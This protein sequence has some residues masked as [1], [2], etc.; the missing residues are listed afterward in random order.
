M[1]M[2]MPNDVTQEDLV[3]SI[4]RLL[5]TSSK[6]YM[7]L[8]R[9][10][11][12]RFGR[13][14]ERSVRYGLR[15]YGLWRGME[16]RQAHHALGLEINMKNLIGC[17][18]SAST[19][20]IKDDLAETG[21]TFKPYDARHDVH[22]CPAAEV[23]T[24]AEFFQWG[25]AYC[26]EFHQACASAY[27]PDG[28]VVIPIN[29]MKGDDHCH[30]QWIMPP[31]SETLDLGE[32]SPLGRRLALDYQDSSEL[33]GAWHAL[34]R[35]NRLVGGRFYTAA[36]VLMEQ[37]GE[38]GIEVI[39]DGLTRWGN[40]R[41]RTLRQEHEAGGIPLN[42]VSFIQ[43]HD[44]PYRQVWQTREIVMEPNH[45]VLEIADSP[46]DEAWDDLKG[47]DLGA[48]WYE[49][50]YAAMAATYL[51]GSSARW[52]KLKSRQDAVNQLEISVG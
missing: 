50:S 45:V 51:P 7:F 35:S 41:G 10:T 13:D 14:G 22:Y 40:E 18:D 48:L 20:V 5:K 9:A 2:V 30:F 39:K 4:K 36:R 42:L 26:D 37:H 8:T 28:N 21:G 38:Q 29:M 44:L 16:M 25:H 3:A 1:T 43:H 34:K 27:H 6:M 49:T 17:W 15:A 47:G 52:P 11:I 24:D 19:Y 12:E 31:N 23:W 46:Q 32:P 33:E